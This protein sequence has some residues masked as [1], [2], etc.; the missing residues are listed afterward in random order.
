MTKTFTAQLRGIKDLTAKKMRYIA[1]EA[2]QDVMEGA[3]TSQP[4]VKQ[5]G[6]TFEIGKIPVETSDL[7]NSLT[8]RVGS[9]GGVSG[10]ESYVTV[11]AGM[12]IGDR[13]EFEW[14]AEH[15]L[16]MEVG[17]TS[18]TG[19]NIPGRHYVGTNAARFREFVETHAA[20]VRK[21]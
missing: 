3:Q 15:A 13:L 10:P 14:T 6:G 18:S 12:E 19:R 20:E 9:G 11:I 16:P 1:A 7:I 5:T 4:G 8:S 17:F 2:I 21:R